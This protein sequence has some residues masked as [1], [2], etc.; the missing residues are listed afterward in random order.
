[1]PG[2]HTVSLVD[3]FDPSQAC[4]MTDDAPTSDLGF[5][6]RTRKSGEVQILH[7]GQLASTLRGAE[8]HDFVA[9]VSSCSVAEAQQIMARVTGNFKR[10]NERLAASHQRNR[11]P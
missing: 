7:R 1:M 3:A 5:T 9:E 4:R 10:G 11:R 6:F 2:T 8:A